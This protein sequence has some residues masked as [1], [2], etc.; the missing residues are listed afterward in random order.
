MLTVAVTVA[1]ELVTVYKLIRRNTQAA[2]AAANEPDV[3][4]HANTH[5]R[6]RPWWSEAPTLQLIHI[7]LFRF[8]FIQ[9]G[10]A[11]YAVRVHN[12][13][14]IR[15]MQKIYH[16]FLTKFDS[17]YLF[18]HKLSHMANPPMKNMSQATMPLPL[19]CV[20]LAEC[21][22][23]ITKPAEISACSHT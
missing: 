1:Y 6:D 12:K 4:Q 7:P 5:T 21:S 14:C 13:L 17:P 3:W 2:A 15:A 9:L 8:V 11:V 18:C 16:A 19:N 23:V 10:L 22:I 20:H